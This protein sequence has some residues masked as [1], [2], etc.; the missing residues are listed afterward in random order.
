MLK[1]SERYRNKDTMWPQFLR[2][3]TILVLN[4]LLFETHVFTIQQF[5]YFQ[6]NTIF[7][8]EMYCCLCLQRPLIQRLQLNTLICFITG[9]FGPQ[10]PHLVLFKNSSSIERS[11][12]FKH[13]YLQK[14]DSKLDEQLLTQAHRRTISEV[15]LH[16]LVHSF[17]FLVSRW[18]F[19]IS[20]YH[21]FA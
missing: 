18:Q 2:L 13:F 4:A 7:Y 19:A 6:A 14:T 3:Y 1:G 20:L 21:F 15:F 10:D 17:V 5:Y 9:R 12:I 11:Q 8:T 16:E